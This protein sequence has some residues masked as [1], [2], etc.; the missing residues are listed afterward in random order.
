MDRADL[1]GFS[2]EQQPLAV[3][4]HYQLLGHQLLKNLNLKGFSL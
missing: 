4:W 1:K 3:G 2:F